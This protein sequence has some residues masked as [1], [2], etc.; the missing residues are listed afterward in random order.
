MNVLQCL[1]TVSYTHLDVYKRQS[2]D[3]VGNNRNFDGRAR[4]V[5]S[6]AGA[7]GYTEYIEESTEPRVTLFHSTDDE[8]VPYESGEP[9]SNLL[10]LVVGSDLP[11]VYGSNPISVQATSVGLAHDFHSYT[12]RGH[13]VHENG[14]NS[15]HGDIVPKISD[16]FY[17][18]LLRPA[19]LV[20]TGDTVI[21]NDQ[22]QQEYKTR[23]DSAAYYDWTVTGGSLIQHSPFSPEVVVLW[24]EN[25]PV[26][27]LS[28]TPYSYHRARGLTKSITVDILLRR[29]N[30]WTGGSGLWNTTSDWSL[31]ISPDVCHN[32]VFPDL[33][34]LS[35]NVT[36]DSTCLLYTSRCV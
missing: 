16:G 2:L 4:A 25:A 31:G 5:F 21:C 9:F 20:I 33:S 15:L 32:V 6:L 30:T 14:S 10:W 27:S 8:T 36:M 19:P 34:D 22:L 24:N 11:V 13:G 3:S 26:K 35:Q 29:T 7:L 18:N 23:Q 1:H 28:V 12:N 17:V